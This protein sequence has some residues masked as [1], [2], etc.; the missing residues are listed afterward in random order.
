M[1]E[2]TAATVFEATGHWMW[3]VQMAMSLA[4]ATLLGSFYLRLRRPLMGWLTAFF[5]SRA[6][7]ALALAL[8]WGGGRQSAPGT[9]V[10]AIIVG[11]LFAA[12]VPLVTGAVRS[13]GTLPSVTRRSLAT[14][15]IGG[16][17]YFVAATTLSRLL[18]AREDIIVNFWGRPLIF[19]VTAGMLMAVVNGRGVP[20]RQTPVLQLLRVGFG[21]LFVCQLIES[22]FRV[23]VSLAADPSF[24]LT[25]TVVANLSGLFLLGIATLLAVIA[26]ERAQVQ[27]MID[28]EVQLGVQDAEAHR[29]EI[30]GRMAN[31]IGRDFNR[32]LSTVAGELEQLRHTWRGG[33]GRSRAHLVAIRDSAAR[34]SRLT[35]RLLILARQQ[36][37]D[38]RHF[39]PADLIRELVPLL[40]RTVS[41]SHHLVTTIDSVQFVNMSLTQCEQLVLN[42]VLNAQDAAHRETTIQLRIE[43]INI[44]TQVPLTHGTC[45]AGTWVRLTVE[46]SG[47][48][49]APDLLP[50]LFD[51]IAVEPSDTG[52]GLGLMAVAQATRSVGGHLHVSS[53]LGMGTR[54]EAWL[55]A[56]APQ[57][58]D[59]Q[60]DDLPQTP[61]RAVRQVTVGA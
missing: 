15:A 6:I 14:W 34:G 53:A 61:L 41:P 20:Q 29:L 42:L 37:G 26:G 36:G 1:Q 35:R 56:S 44:T 9:F 31:G 25:A 21:S 43:D 48:G 59:T 30:L 18:D 32:V 11:S 2:S 51:P 23:R 57:P 49:I 10:L 46:D 39:R 58:A 5:L 50:H 40:S 22:V 45:H 38:H 55:P 60:S 28:R 33:Y 52:I 24:D 17:A 27:A 54:I 4:F 7:L 19:I 13:L 12:S 47:A 8:Y 16:A 3:L